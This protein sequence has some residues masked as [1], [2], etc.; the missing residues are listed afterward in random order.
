MKKQGNEEVTLM[1]VERLEQE[2]RDYFITEVQQVEPP[3][4]WWD[5]I[6]T[7]LEEQKRRSLWSRFIPRTRL[8]WVLL[9][10]VFLVIG[11][12]VYAATSLIADFFRTLAPDIEEAGLVVTLNLSQ[13]IDGVTVRLEQGY[14]DSN[15][16]LIGYTVTGRNARYYS[17]ARELSLVGGQ[18]LP[19]MG[20]LGHVPT[21]NL[22]D[23]Y[24]AE[25]TVVVAFDA[26]A[27]EGAP[28]ELNLRFET[29]V[30]DSPTIAE[31]GTTWGPFVFD[32]TLPFHVGKT[33]VIEQ[34]TEAAG[35]PIT[36]EKVVITPS[37]T[38]AVY[39]FH[40]EYEDNRKRPLMIS[41]L[42]PSGG[43]ADDSNSD[44]VRESFTWL[45]ESYSLQGFP[46]DFT[47]RTGEWMLTVTELVF[48]PRRQ[49]GQVGDFGGPASDVKRLSGPW[50]FQFE[51]P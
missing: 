26:S 12:T 23:W 39:R 22:L 13:T 4:E 28:E 7:N 36:L 35:V 10:L 20:G 38:G 44:E 6:V 37:A 50:V 31:S 9:P 49:P 14:A 29:T 51:V 21:L 2:L 32:F 1:E 47:N 25:T 8:A 24:P 48:V 46:G 34:T 19:A 40:G 41:S 11:G 3:R 30:G 16:V 43:S 27:V 17:D 18:N 42:Q 5:N 33:V 45:G 15:T